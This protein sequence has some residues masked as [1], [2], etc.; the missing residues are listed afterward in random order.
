MRPYQEL[1]AQ[2]EIKVKVAACIMLT[3]LGRQ[4][5]GGEAAQA[6]GG[7]VAQCRDRRV[8]VRPR[9]CAEVAGGGTGD[10]QDAGGVSG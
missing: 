9:P 3:D 4:G 2:A 8:L 6:G 10:G 5:P 7:E 1:K